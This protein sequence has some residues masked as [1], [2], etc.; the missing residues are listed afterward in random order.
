MRNRFL[1]DLPSK[2]LRR[3]IPAATN[4]APKNVEN[5]ACSPRKR[6]ARKDVIRGFIPTTELV[7]A[8]P[9]FSI[10]IKF[11]SLPNPRAKAPLIAKRVIANQSISGMSAKR[12][13][14]RIATCIKVLIRLALRGLDFSIPFE[15]NMLETALETDVI[16][17]RK[18][19]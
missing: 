2:P 1:K 7:M 13:T 9:I 15:I 6:M 18:F 4:I 11:R 16:R 3:N 5:K 14:V 17:E 10:D 12:K 8:T 19:Q